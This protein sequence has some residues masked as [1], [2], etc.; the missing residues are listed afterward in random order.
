M[1]L[2][3]F[4]VQI[5]KLNVVQKFI[6]LFGFDPTL[7]LKRANRKRQKLILFTIITTFIPYVPHGNAICC[8][9]KLVVME[10][11]CYVLFN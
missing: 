6:I 5:F 3:E 8:G 1:C 11:A 4:K 2:S 9:K 7:I 10:G